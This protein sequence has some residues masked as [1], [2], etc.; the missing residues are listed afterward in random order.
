LNDEVLK[1]CCSNGG[2]LF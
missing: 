1:I 2:G